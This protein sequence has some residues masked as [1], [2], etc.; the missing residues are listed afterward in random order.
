VTGIANPA[1]LLEYLHEKFSRMIHL[2][3]SDHHRFT[4]GDMSR[5]LN[6][7]NSLET[8]RKFIIT[9]EKDAI[10]LQEFTKISEPARSAFFYIPVGI[11]F[12]NNARSDFDETITDYVRKNQRDGTVS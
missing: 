1:P 2:P 3:F 12:L 10:R 8:R 9:T 11:S 6:A 7:W 4:P 5:I